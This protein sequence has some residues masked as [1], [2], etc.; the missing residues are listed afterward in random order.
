MTTRSWIRNMFNRPSNVPN[1][2]GAPRTCLVLSTMEVRVVPTVY[3]PDLFTDAVSSSGIHTLRDAIIAANSDPGINTD[4][5][6]LGTGTYT[7]TI[8]NAGSAQEN[9]AKTGDLDITS[10]AHKLSIVGKGSSGASATIIDASALMDRVF[11][12]VNS[13]TS[14]EFDNLVIKGGLAQDN[15]V[16]GAV[17]GS[18]TAEG[19][20]IFNSGGSL[21]F[22]NVVFQS[23]SA[24]GGVGVNG[25]IGVAGSN[26]QS[27]QGGGLYS[28]AGS[29]GLATVT[30]N[31]NVALG[32][33]GGIGGR[34]GNYGTSSPGGAAGIG[35]GGG[36]YSG[37]GTVTITQST[38][39]GNT[40][41]GGAGGA[42]GSAFGVAVY[43]SSGGLGGNGGKGQGGGVY[44]E[45]P[46]TITSSTINSN[47]ARG[48]D[49]G[50]GGISTE[51]FPGGALGGTGG[52]GGAGDTGQGGGVFAGGS[53][54]I[55]SCVLNADTAQGGNGGNGGSASYGGGG[56]PGHGGAGGN[57][58]SGQGGGLYAS[59]GN[60]TIGSSS[61]TSNVA[62]GGAG[63][64]G[65]TCGLGGN[66]N[67]GNAG[68]G[69]VGEGG[70][71][72]YLGASIQFTSFTCTGNSAQGGAGGLGGAGYG[73]FGYGGNGGNGGNSFGGGLYAGSGSVLISN[74]TFTSDIAQAGDGGLSP[75][76][77]GGTKVGH[78]GNGGSGG[79]SK[80]G[81]VFAD[82]ASIEITNSTFST[83]TA[84]GGNGNNA[85]GLAFQV[86]NGG[87]GGDGM[88]GGLYALS[89][90]ATIT[91][92]N[93]TLNSDSALG[94]NGGMSGAYNSPRVNGNGGLGQGGGLFANSAVVTVTSST[95]S[96]NVA[97]G[98]NGAN[99]P[100]ATVAVNGGTGGNGQGGAIYVIGAPVTVSNAT[101]ASNLATGGK[102]GN[103]GTTVNF[104]YPGGNGGNGGN[105]QGA[106]FYAGAGGTVFN[107]TLSANLTKGGTAGS[108]G[109]GSPSGKAG[110]AGTNQGGGLFVGGNIATLN[111]SIV[112]GSTGGD[113]VISGGALN[114]SFNL[115]QDGSGGLAGT[116][117][118]NPMLG[119][120]A[121]YSGPT[122]TLPLLP[123]SLAIN[124]GTSTDAPL[125]DQRGLPRFGAVDIGAFERQATPAVTG[126]VLNTTTLTVANVGP[127]G[128]TV[129]ATFNGAMDTSVQPLV[130]FPIEPINGTLTFNSSSWLDSTHWVAKYDVANS[131]VN[132]PNVDLRITGG[133]NLDGTTQTQFDAPDAFNV[134]MQTASVSGFAVNQGY[135][136]SFA[137]QRSR[138]VNVVVNFTAPV[139]AAQFQT[140]GNVTLTRTTGSP[141]VLNTSNG[142]IVSPASG[143]VSSITLTFA[144]VS[145]AGIDNASLPD[146]NWRLGVSTAGYTGTTTDIRRL[147]GD[148]DGNG[149][150]D[151]AIDFPAFGAAFNTVSVVS[152]FDFDGNGSVDGAID[153]PAF[154]AR[155]N[156]TL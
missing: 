113:I 118:A 56:P 3:T 80:G 63:G 10:T 42:G 87:N 129:T 74:S 64:S 132:L 147:F 79:S 106:G 39:T 99:D 67:G 103:G 95:L 14:V 71:A 69:G 82:T 126:I 33:N 125:S 88:G 59:S 53:F 29:I 111:N 122:S 35:V 92:T 150:V 152:P 60:D 124:A 78:G 149:S 28:S 81:G 43:S 123:S 89:A 93:S 96:T 133:K 75:G 2:M 18:S 31:Q 86:G 15:G 115:V 9:A 54:T 4:T 143:T 101:L 24:K 41:Q 46:M 140:A 120:L 30:F 146:G 131:G 102:G 57:G 38:F 40:A 27:A 7:L 68:I 85:S 117:V 130:S 21:T 73:Q 32:G 72:Y 108:A 49:G 153:F 128:F 34:S 16:A 109:L 17:A 134:A 154:G 121:T 22:Q 151:G 107:S 84:R 156:T 66:L 127:N 45:G 97:Q 138:V 58:A 52:T 119:P 13:G 135:G 50:A 65:G 62:L 141:I 91:L 20:G 6:N 5:I 55:D 47:T 8:T 148:T 155:F 1:R 144:N 12:I 139:N 19:G 26:G 11:Q 104:T 51:G 145:Q 94:G 37:T 25:A 44:A 100:T 70:G 116:I 142:L 76:G 110:V 83:E 98:G 114:G 90:S 23:N 137:A 112:A 36:L 136:T 105:G 77:F 61:V 48:G